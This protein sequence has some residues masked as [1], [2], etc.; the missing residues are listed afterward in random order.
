M[1][2][3]I[4]GAMIITFLY[5]TQTEEKTKMSGDPAITTLIIAASAVAIIAYGIT[6]P[7][8]NGA[9]NYNPASAMA[10]TWSMIFKGNLD[11]TDQTW[12]FLFFSYFG[13]L[14][15]VFMFECIYK[16]AMVT[17]EEQ[18]ERDDDSDQ[19]DALISP[20]AA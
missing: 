7:V 16:K 2:Q 20:T 14:L 8:T 11:D 13:S 4:I 6:S 15:A 1:I 18:E 5:L 10:V 17:V 19:H 3:E 12:M 9:S